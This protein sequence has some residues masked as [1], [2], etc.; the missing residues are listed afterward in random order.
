MRVRACVCVRVPV[1]V[2]ACEC[3]SVRACAPVA[4][5]PMRMLRPLAQLV[6]R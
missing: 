6:R 1:R 3:V 4:D 5:L 2:C